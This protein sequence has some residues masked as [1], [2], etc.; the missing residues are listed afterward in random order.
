MLKPGAST[1]GGVFIC[2]SKNNDPVLSVSSSPP[3]SLICL[4]G[5]TPKAKVLGSISYQCLRFV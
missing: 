4:A 1:H 2:R 5:G 3:L